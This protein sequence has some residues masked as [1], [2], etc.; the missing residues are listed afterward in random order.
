MNH[1]P[2]APYDV[3]P[4]T[5]AIRRIKIPGLGDISVDDID[6]Q[7]KQ[8][9]DLRGVAKVEAMRHASDQQM[10]DAVALVRRMKGE[11]APEMQAINR[12]QALPEAAG[13]YT[14]GMEIV[15]ANDDVRSVHAATR[16]LNRPD[17]ANG[18]SEGTVVDMGSGPMRVM[19]DGVVY[20]IESDVAAASGVHYLAEDGALSAATEVK[21]VTKRGREKL[22]SPRVR[23]GL[24][25]VAIAL[26]AG[27]GI[28]AV[29]MNSAGK[30]TS[31]EQGPNNPVIESAV[32]PL[33]SVAGKLAESFDGCLNDQGQGVPILRAKQTAIVPESWPYTAPDKSKV[34]LSATLNGQTVK[35]VVKLAPPSASD[36]SQPDWNVGITACVT[37]DNVA[38]VVT[39]DEKTRTVTIDYSKVSPQLQEGASSY[40]VGFMRNDTDTTATKGEDVIRALLDKKYID[41]AEATRLTTAYTDKSNVTAESAQAVRRASEAIVKSGDIYE[42]QIS[43][44]LQTKIQSLVKAQLD[45]LRSQGAISKDD[46][47]VKTTNDMNPIAVVGPEPAKADAFT[48][49]QAKIIQ[50]E[51]ASEANN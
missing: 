41:Q 39:V 40:L 2:N 28:G 12:H 32:L 9:N 23:I 43:A 4:G 24:G 1:E 14:Q 50:F 8:L 42:K 47:T 30:T 6:G 7:I 35:P 21:S 29:Q 36:K 34:V 16:N 5:E 13:D 37:K 22:R 27:G 44:S 20:R 11:A 19:P 15:Y 48:T 18:V 26:V 31:S 49:D 33:A 25:V 45:T 10:L 3:T 38:N 17:Y 46:V 51:I